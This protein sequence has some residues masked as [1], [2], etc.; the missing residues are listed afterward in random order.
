MGHQRDNQVSSFKVKAT[1][2]FI[3]KDGEMRQHLSLALGD[4]AEGMAVEVT[5]ESPGRTLKGPLPAVEE[6]LQDPLIEVPAVAEPTD[7]KISIVAGGNKA[8]LTVKVMPQKKWTLYL[9]EHV[10][11]D[12]GYTSAQP[13]EARLHNERLDELVALCEKTRDWPA[14]SA[15]KWNLEV[16]WQME[17]YIE[18]R[19]DDE[20][21][22]LINLV[23]D[24][25][26]EITGAYVNILTEQCGHEELARLGYFA[27]KL[28][29]DYGISISS[30][31]LTDTPGYTWAV[32]MVLR[33]SGIRYLSVGTNDIWIPFHSKTDLPPLFYWQ[34]PDGSEV[35]L[36][37]TFVYAHAEW[38]GLHHSYES[39]LTNIPLYLEKYWAREDYPYDTILLH[40]GYGDN[41]R[42]WYRVEPGVC[43]IIRR[44]NERWA[45]PRIILSTNSEFFQEMEKEHGQ[46]LRRV[47]AD[48]GSFWGDGAAAAA[49]EMAINRSTHERL[50]FA[51]KLATITSA[52]APDVSYPRGDLEDAYRLMI[53][54]DEHT[55]GG[56]ETI[57]DPGGVDIRAQWALKSGYA[58]QGAALT[59][60]ILEDNL[61]TMTEVIPNGEEPTLAVFNPL[62]WKRTDLVRVHV[63][64]E[65]MGG[66]AFQIVD[67][68]TGEAVPCQIRVQEKN[69]PITKANQDLMEIVFVARDVPATGYRLYR[70]LPAQENKEAMTEMRISD[71]MMENRFFRLTFDEATGGISS[72]FDKELKRELVD[73]ESP[74]LFNQLIY[75]SGF[76]KTCLKGARVCYPHVDESYAFYDPRVEKRFRRTSPTKAEILPGENGPVLCSMVAKTR[77]G[78]CSAIRQEVVLYQDIKRIDVFNYLEKKEVWDAEAIY[79]SFPFAVRDGEFLCELSDAQVRPDKDQFPGAGRDWYAVQHWAD[80]SN[81]QHG[82][83]LATREAYLFEFCD[84]NTGKA[85]THL[86]FNNATLFS[87]IMNNYWF[88][89][90]PGQQGGKFVFGYSVQ[91]HPGSV[92]R[93]EATHFG[94]GFNNPLLGEFLEPAGDDPGKTDGDAVTDLWYT[95]EAQHKKRKRILPDKECSFC[96]LDGDQAIL[97]ALKQAEDGKGYIARLL[98]IAGK[99]GTVYVRFPLFTIKQAWLTNIVE[100]NEKPLAVGEKGIEVQ[101]KPFGFSTIRFDLNT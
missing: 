62:S 18:H 30:A 60:I 40:G 37:V 14:G 27:E 25:R 21:E 23:R 96:E 1:P 45:Y 82:V 92:N 84:I 36:W 74:Y 86:P 34:G 63:P 56:E 94:S 101:L 33:G 2:F 99:G 46:E 64:V 13:R 20:I 91:S 97:L 38:I 48:W 42:P 69:G 26:M 77:V 61:K 54:F 100:A 29:R 85:L 59:N 53:F 12:F 79:Y 22:K 17:N 4:W 58:Y 57:N 51:E 10:H 90:Y 66:K 71:G 32:P 5:L 43:D 81:E 3:E 76:S 52:L 44:W 11:T 93:I 98:E 47:R 70:M 68:G 35:L 75:D 31:I 50:P 65:V 39:L 24:G 95:P 19:S 72:I 41:Y 6:G 87:Y 73:E 16:S 49:R 7:M 78:P 9:S 28:R 83:T 89:N 55:Y 88:T 8:S 67:E 80:V 15:F